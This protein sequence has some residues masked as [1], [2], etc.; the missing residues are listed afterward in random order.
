[1]LEIAEVRSGDRVLD[2]GCGPGANGILAMD[3][4]GPDGHVAFVD[5]NIRAMALAEF[6]AKENGVANHRCVPTPNMEGLD[7]ASFDL[8]LANPP[9]YANSWIAQMFIEKS[10][11]LLRPGGRFYLVT[12]M[13]N[14]VAPIMAG[15][16]PDS[17]WEERR[18]YHV[19][20]GDVQ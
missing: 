16:F 5:S 14:H 11:P 19:L 7:A 8:I 12:K 4:A 6:N 3:R 13:V 9:Y 17:T 15:I 10:K 1:M 18:G 20:R 2:L